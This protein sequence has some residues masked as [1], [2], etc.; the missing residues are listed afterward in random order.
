[1]EVKETGDVLTGLNRLWIWS[2]DGANVDK[3]KSSRPHD[4]RGI[5]RWTFLKN[6]R[7]MV[8]L[9]VMLKLE[10]THRR[11]RRFYV[12]LT[13]EYNVKNFFQV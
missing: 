11:N 5:L 10:F 13:E 4:I 9:C 3:K 2:S 6:S 8:A 7:R 1:L 12:G